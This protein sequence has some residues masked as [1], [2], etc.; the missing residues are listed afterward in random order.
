[1]KIVMRSSK[2]EQLKQFK[3]KHDI[4]CQEF[5]QLIFDT[6]QQFTQLN[7]E[8]LNCV[9]D[10]MKQDSLV[11]DDNTDYLLTAIKSVEDQQ[12][13]YQLL[14]K[15]IMPTSNLSKEQV[16]EIEQIIE[17]CQQ[18]AIGLSILGKMVAFYDYQNRQIMNKFVNEFDVTKTNA[19]Q[20]GAACIGLALGQYKDKQLWDDIASQCLKLDKDFH[21]YMRIATGMGLTN[22]GNVEFWN[23]FIE[24]FRKQLK[25]INE[26]LF[27]QSLQVITQQ[28]VASLELCEAE[29]EYY[30]IN[31]HIR[32]ENMMS[33][34][35][36]MARKQLGSQQLYSKLEQDI[37]EMQLSGDDLILYLIE[38]MQVKDRLPNQT[39]NFLVAKAY[40][41]SQNQDLID[42]LTNLIK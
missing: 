20:L 38:L 18:H 29:I 35:V 3:G 25:T 14:D 39:L 9:V 12:T 6:R 26:D 36:S 32:I 7:G 17:S 11:D 1:M 21:S 13:R 37:Y 19:E 10:L 23:D 16:K 42:K 27:T 34:Y 31:S 41:E 30:I 28:N 15:I 2:L 40:S 5:K 24:Q 4:S 8:Q 33:I 22:N